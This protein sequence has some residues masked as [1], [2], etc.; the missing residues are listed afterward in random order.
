MSASSVYLYL[1]TPGRKWC[2]ELYEQ[3]LTI[4]VLWWR[5]DG[6]K[7]S[8]N[9]IMQSKYRIQIKGGGL[10]HPKCWFWHTHTHTHTHTM[11]TAIMHPHWQT[12]YN[13]YY[14][15]RTNPVIVQYMC[16]PWSRRIWVSL[17]GS[18]SFLSYG[19]SGRGNSWSTTATWTIIKHLRGERER[20][21]E[22]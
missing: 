7:I 4:T 16:I 14:Y 12:W 10:V 13:Y 8:Q 6:S 5:S 22:R 2:D 20:K 17:V 1:Y 19:R 9:L 11:K 21:R 18:K 3:V 15:T